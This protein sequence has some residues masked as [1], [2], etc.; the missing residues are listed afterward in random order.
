LLGQQEVE[1]MASTVPSQ[2][3]MPICFKLH[4]EGLKPS[5]HKIFWNGV[6]WVS[7]NEYEKII[8]GGI[9]YRKST[10]RNQSLFQKLFFA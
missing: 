4:T 3:Y 1:V 9:K 8:I 7:K 10:I 2:M 6:K 5:S